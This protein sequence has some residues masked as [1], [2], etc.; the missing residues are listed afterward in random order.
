MIWLNVK[1]TSGSNRSWSESPFLTRGWELEERSLPSYLKIRALD[2]SFTLHWS[3]QLESFNFSLASDACMAPSWIPCGMTMT[4]SWSMRVQTSD[5]VGSKPMGFQAY[6]GLSWMPLCLIPLPACYPTSIMETL[7][8]LKLLRASGLVKLSIGWALDESLSDLSI[9]PL[10]IVFSSSHL[11]LW[12]SGGLTLPISCEETITR[13]WS[14]EVFFA[15]VHFVKSN[16]GTDLQMAWVQDALNLVKLKERTLRQLFFYHHH[17]TSDDSCRCL[18]LWLPRKCFWAEA[19]P[20]SDCQKILVGSFRSVWKL[21]WSTHPLDIFYPVC[22]HDCIPNWRR[23]SGCLITYFMN[24][25][26][27]NSLRVS[28]HVICITVGSTFQT[29][30]LSLAKQQA[31]R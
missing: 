31:K 2:C 8:L 30:L 4:S 24:L 23:K 6:F 26:Y 18:I 3:F 22:I 14:R 11:E 7:H 21:V 10:K 13:E 12:C 1:F 17:I 9:K 25:F 5:F 20:L 29:I 27:V 16:V 15:F 28:W 19:L